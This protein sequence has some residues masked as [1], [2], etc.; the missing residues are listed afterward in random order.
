MNDTSENKSLHRAIIVVALGFLA[1][2]LVFSARAALGLAMPIWE[3]DL[4]WSRGYVSNV[5]A[6]ALLIMAVASP[7]SGFILD[8]KGLR[9]TLLLGLIAVF[10]SCIVISMAQSAWVLLIGFGIIGGVGFGIVATHMVAS[11][12]ARVYPENVGF[13]S[14]IATSGSSAGQF[15]IV[16]LI[17]LIF[18]S[19]SWRWGF[20]GIAVGIACLI[21]LVWW[22]PSDKPDKQVSKASTINDVTDLKFSLK[23]LFS[24][25]VF[26]LLFWSYLI[27]GYTTTGVIETHLMPFASF[28]GFEP[29]PSAAAYGLLSAVNLVGMISIG[30]LTDKMNRPLLLGCIYIIRGFTF[31]ILLN[32]GTSYET[33]LLF[34]VIF[35]VVDYSTVPVTASLVASHIGLKV[36][37][38]TMG[39]LSAGHSIGAA[40]AASLGGYF[41]DRDAT[42]D[43]IWIS[44]IALATIAGVLAFLIK[45]NPSQKL[46]VQ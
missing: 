36:M 31:W 11:A 3:N 14:G 27:C 18:A 29:I 22:V 43:L 25:P 16:P 38:L 37:G 23:K 1:L 12:V 13:A 35:G 45:D 7:I 24:T 5:A 15:L 40:I 46:R 34:A 39:L 33:L 10:I 30:W 6:V 19:F 32:V 2:A 41:F 20:A 4:D 28:C 42:Y 21:P 17:A 8:R 44:S 26:H 9:F